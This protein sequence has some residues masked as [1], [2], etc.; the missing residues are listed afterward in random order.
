MGRGCL[1]ALQRRL[2]HQGPHTANCGCPWRTDHPSGAL[3]PKL[4]ASTYTH[5]LTSDPSAPFPSLRFPVGLQ[6]V[7]LSEGSSRSGTCPD[8]FLSS[9]CLAQGLTP[10][11]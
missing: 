5:G 11:G 10:H 8:S 7:S 3:C 9:R 6:L 1:S 4:R 2:M